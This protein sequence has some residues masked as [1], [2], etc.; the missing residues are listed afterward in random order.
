MGIRLQE[1]TK[2]LAESLNI[3]NATGVLVA[4]VSSGS[5]AAKAGLKRG[6]VIVS[7]HGTPVQDPGQLRNIVAMTAPGTK[8]TLGIL[9]ENRKQEISVTLG[10][11]PRQAAAQTG[12]GAPPAAGL[13]FSVQNLTADL[14]RQLGYDTAEAV[15]VTQVD[16]NSE[17]YQAGLRRGMLIRQ[18]NRQ[19]VHNTEEFRR[20]LGQSKPPKRVLLLVQDQE[21]TRYIAF[22]LA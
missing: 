1:L 2:S 11:L 20:A 6:D 3:P 22:S 14:A 5:P 17:A 8:T 16:P 15:V 4:D 12:E 18:V 10:E 13:G 9:R 21:A 19:D 7:V